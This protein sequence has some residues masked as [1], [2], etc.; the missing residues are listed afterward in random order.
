MQRAGTSNRAGNQSLQDG[1]QHQRDGTA[2]SL[3]RC[4]GWP[5]QDGLSPLPS[6]E[7]MALRVCDLLLCCPLFY[8]NAC[9]IS[10]FM[11]VIGM[12]PIS[13]SMVVM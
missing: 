3:L 6:D 4:Q 9:V 12:V 7:G 2:G 10:V 1:I 8:V 13:F 11:F 5:R